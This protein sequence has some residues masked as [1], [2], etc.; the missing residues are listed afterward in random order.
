MAFT[1]RL[2]SINFHGFGTGIPYEPVVSA[3]AILAPVGSGWLLIRGKSAKA[4]VEEC[5]GDVEGRDIYFGTEAPDGDY[6]RIQLGE[7][8]AY[9]VGEPGRAILNMLGEDSP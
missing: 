5:D 7:G 6:F 4:I 2:P 1:G 9:I 3:D 8:H